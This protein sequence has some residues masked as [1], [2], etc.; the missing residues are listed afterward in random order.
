ML[1]PIDESEVKLKKKFQEYYYRWDDGGV[2]LISE[3]EIGFIPFFGTMIRHRAVSN[4][5]GL[6][7]FV[8][9]NVPRHIYYSSA[10][11]RKPDEK[12]MKDKEWKGAELIFDLD[13]D[14]IEGAEK[15]SYVEILAEVKK[16]TERLIFKFLMD[17]LGFQ[18]K[19]L[20]LFFSGG[21]GYH[22]HVVEDSVY[23]LASDARREIANYIRGEG[24]SVFDF[25]RSMQ[26]SSGRLTGWKKTV[27]GEV[28]NFYSGLIDDPEKQETVHRILGNSRSVPPYLANQKKATEVAGNLKKNDVFSMPGAIKY[29]LMDQNDD[30]VLA[31]LLNKVKREYQ[32][33]IDEPVTTD[34]H[35]LIR[36]PY[37]LHGKTG[38]MV[39]PV[40]INDLKNFNPLNDAI[41]PSF[42]GSESRVN[43][44]R[45]FRME[46]SGQS[47]DMAP[48]EEVVPTDLAVFMVA[49][50]Y[51]N[52][53]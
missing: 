21:R 31:Y 28:C 36:L 8:R 24:I 43:I 37:S 48:G 22:V 14:H 32:C 9:R 53:I 15:M 6:A 25:K 26:D 30:K 11:Y 46:F 1:L 19:D 33:E 35:R 4:M 39:K 29:R 38:L 34:I 17:E 23:P 3:R 12:I 47:F 49:G 20:K 27:D 52:F 50:K 13:A 16:H 18:E 44:L 51:A 10:Y 2:D 5:N 42:S 40:D 41:A 45:N 7:H